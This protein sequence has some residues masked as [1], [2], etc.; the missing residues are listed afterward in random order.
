[1]RR[2]GVSCDRWKSILWLGLRMH[3]PLPPSPISEQQKRGAIFASVQ[4]SLRSLTTVLSVMFLIMVS[5][6]GWDF[7]WNG[8]KPA[9]NLSL[10]M[11]LGSALFMLT[12]RIVVG[13]WT[14]PNRW[15][16]PT[17]FLAG[18]VVLL[19]TDVQLYES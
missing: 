14:I 15:I 7:Y 10:V 11:E 17:L 5:A 9:K 2:R 1:M 4:E 12:L 3:V 16:H 6:H 13:R 19:N 8:Y 18:M